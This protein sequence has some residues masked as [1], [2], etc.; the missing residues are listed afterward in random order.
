V[1]TK[2]SGRDVRD[3]GKNQ[4]RY[5]WIAVVYEGYDWAIDWLVYGLG[6]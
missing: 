3:E 1:I 4:G 6:R 5:D 2:H